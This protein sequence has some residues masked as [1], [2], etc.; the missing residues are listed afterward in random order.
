MMIL[1][2]ILLGYGIYC[3]VKNRDNYRTNANVYHN[4]SQADKQAAIAALELRYVNGEV[5]DVTFLKMK[6]TLSE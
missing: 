2:W 1:F 5:D 4:H 6:K 3:L